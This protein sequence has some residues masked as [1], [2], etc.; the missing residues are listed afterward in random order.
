MKA[1]T[2]TINHLQ[3]WGS[4]VIPEHLTGFALRR[5]DG[6]LCAIAM[7]CLVLK[8]VNPAYPPGWW[9]WFNSRGPVS[10]IAHRYTL[11]VRDAL[12]EAGV[13]V[14]H[15]FLDDSIPKAE[16]WMRRLGFELVKDDLWRLDL[17]LDGEGICRDTGG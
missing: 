16:T 15:A 3:E 14:I 6:E 1:E 13:E 8:P 12:K 2:L 7:A 17:V 5:D 11:K 9:V 10:P 4:E